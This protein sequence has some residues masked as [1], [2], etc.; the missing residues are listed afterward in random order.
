LALH[1]LLSGPGRWAYV[2]AVDR[3]QAAIIADTIASFVRGSD[4]LR[5]SL[6][7]G[8]FRIVAPSTASVLEVLAADAASS[9]GLR[10]SLL[11]LDEL[12]AWPRQA[13]VFFQALFSSL[14]KVPGARCLV[15]TTAGWDRRGLCWKL[16]EQ[17]QLDPAWV[18]SRRGQCAAWVLGEFLEQQR[19]I[20]PR[21]IYQML[22]ENI[23]TQAG[24]AFLTWGEID[25]VFRQPALDPGDYFLGIDI[26]TSFG[27]DRNCAGCSA[28]QW[29]AALLPCPGVWCCRG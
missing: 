8:R 24:T 7:V 26:G 25:A 20:L 17:V 27:G 2:A 14:G 28:G 9:W 21:H 4:L 22:H 29:R 19:R 13:E 15:A 23:W 18:F 10:P 12:S 5:E 16:R 3:D 1:H 6:E 11:V